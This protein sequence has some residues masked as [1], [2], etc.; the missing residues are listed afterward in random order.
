MNDMETEQEIRSKL[1]RDFRDSVSRC[2]NA[3]AE[4]QL[5]MNKLLCFDDKFFENAQK[6][7]KDLDLA[8]LLQLLEKTNGKIREAILAAARAIPKR[9]KSREAAKKRIKRSAKKV[10]KKKQKAAKR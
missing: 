4:Q 6:H 2:I 5:C 8:T 10:A 1:L 9:R 3:M 7:K